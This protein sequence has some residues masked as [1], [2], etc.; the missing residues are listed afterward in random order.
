MLAHARAQQ[1][2]RILNRTEVEDLAQHEH[3]VAANARALDS[4]ERYSIECAYLVGCDGASSMVRKAIGAE[5][6]GDP[7][8][9]H[10]QST[11]YRAPA[12]I[13]MLPGRPAWNYLSWNPR[14]CGSMMA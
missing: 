13:K 5:F 2:I 1:R 6:V 10:V 9:Q 3:G 4:G 14:R 11:Y 8:V 7:A 12:L